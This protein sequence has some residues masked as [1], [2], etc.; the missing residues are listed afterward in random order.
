[1]SACGV[2]LTRRPF[3]ASPGPSRPAAAA[4][5]GPDA[6]AAFGHS[7][8]GGSVAFWC[9]RSRS[10]VAVLVNRLSADK[11]ASREVVALLARELG[12]T[13]ALSGGF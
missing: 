8:A 11:R 13:E 4:P 7:G 5:T 1:M 2:A 12:V 9:A 10:G 3:C 6:P